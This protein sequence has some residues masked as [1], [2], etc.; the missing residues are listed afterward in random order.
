[1]KTEFKH[2]LLGLYLMGMRWVGLDDGGYYA[3]YEEEPE[4]LWH[5]EFRRCKGKNGYFVFSDDN[6]MLNNLCNDFLNLMPKEN[7]P[8]LFEI[9]PWLKENWLEGYKLTKILE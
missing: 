8:Y 9:L 4:V 3:A 2:I 5:Y 6:E 1:M 7:E